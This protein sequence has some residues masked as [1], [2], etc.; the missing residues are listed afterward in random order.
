MKLNKLSFL[1]ASALLFVSAVSLTSCDHSGSFSGDF[2][3]QASFSDIPTTAFNAEGY[4]DECYEEDSDK[5]FSSVGAHFTHTATV[6]EW[7]GVKYYS[8]KGFCPSMSTDLEDYT[9]GNWTDHQWS[10]MT[11]F[12]LQNNR[13]Y[14]IGCWDVQEKFDEPLSATTCVITCD[15][16]KEFKPY[17]ITVTNTTYGYYV[18]KNGSAFSDPFTNEDKLT[19]RASGILDGKV[20]GYVDIPLA[21]DG[22]YLVEFTEFSLV[23]LGTVDKVVFTMSSTDSG[24]WGMNTPA[25]FAVAD[26]VYTVYQSSE[27]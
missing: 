8:W 11:T 17:A 25:Y 18:M 16:S 14:A 22:K 3:Y 9:E 24:Q 15:F 27:E 6:T 20:T 1:G 26:F 5:G 21:A 4:W 7:D 13:K 2:F 19:L 10:A 23:R 12:P